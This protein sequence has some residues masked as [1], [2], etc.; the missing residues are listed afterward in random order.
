MVSAQRQKLGLTG[1][2]ALGAVLGVG[3][4]E[5]GTTAQF[6]E[7]FVHLTLSEAVVEWRHG[8]IAAVLQR[9]PGEIGIDTSASIVA[10]SG[11]L[12]SAGCADGAGTEAG[13]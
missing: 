8:N 10:R 2:D 6:E 1:R 5:G 7:G 11:H 13:A 4:R 9:S 12:T 3:W